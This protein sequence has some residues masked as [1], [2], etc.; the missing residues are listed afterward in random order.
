[1]DREFEQIQ[2]QIAD[3]QTKEAEIEKAK[4]EVRVRMIYA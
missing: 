1:M 3:I 4:N 2:S